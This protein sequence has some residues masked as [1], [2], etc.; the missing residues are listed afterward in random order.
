MWLVVTIAV[1][2]AGLL[3]VYIAYPVWRSRS[4]LLVD[5]NHPVADLLQRKDAALQQIKELEFDFNTGKLSAEDYERINQRL[6]QQATTL[7]RQI[8][9]IAPNSSGLDEELEALI[10]ERRKTIV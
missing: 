6:R 10:A 1:L 5:D 9:V 8:E 2:I 7:L 4:Q 3:V